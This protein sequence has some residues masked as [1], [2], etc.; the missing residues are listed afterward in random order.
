[1]TLVAGES[2]VVVIL[3]GFPIDVPSILEFIVEVLP[4][5]EEGDEKS[6]EE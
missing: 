4:G 1:M 6:D 3:P 2:L 5:D